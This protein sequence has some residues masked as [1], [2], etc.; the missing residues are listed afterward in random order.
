MLTFLYTSEYDNNT[1][2]LLLQLYTQ[3]YSLADKY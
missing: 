2:I 3:M 1:K